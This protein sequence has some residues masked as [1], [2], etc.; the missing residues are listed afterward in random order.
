MAVSLPPIPGLRN[1]LIIVGIIAAVLGGGYLL[2]Q[3]GSNATPQYAPVSLKIWGTDPGSAF[4]QILQRYKA[5]SPNVTATYEQI[6][7]GNYASSLIHAF[8][9]GQ[10]PDVFMIGD[11]DLGAWK[12]LLS[13]ANI[14]QFNI[15]Q[16]DSSYPE[17]VMSDFV[18]DGEVYAL[19]LY[20][21]TLSLVYNKSWFDQAGIAV[22]PATW[23]DFSD[24]V[25][26]LR[27][28]NAQGQLVKTGAAIG[29]S[30]ATI[31]HA[32][33]ILQLL[34][35][36]NGARILDNEGRANFAGGNSPAEKAFEYYLSFADPASENYTWNEDQ[37]DSF[38]QFLTGKTA[39]IFAY[40]EETKKLQERS[41]FL[42]FDIAPVPQINAD[43]PVN[44]PSYQGLGAWVNGASPAWAWNFISFAAINSAAQGDYLNATG[45]LPALRNLIGN[46]ADDPVAGPMVKPALTA[47]SWPM[48]AHENVV[49]IFSDAVSRVL[50]GTMSAAESLTQAEGKLN[51]LLG[52]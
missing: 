5:V 35:L 36:Q 30:E 50:K 15:A 48:P 16:V 2:F 24:D 9:T 13:P 52:K 10:G 37:G 45:R 28:L 19:P 51:Q 33:D 26:K 44:F 23:K 3:S 17:A 49:T 8:A 21:D 40:R 14:R 41:P 22:P 42:N 43:S 47:R 29:G 18:S 1:K 27:T 34:M 38:E 6:P 25:Q 20:M 4:E 12:S 7:P 11:H 31:T 32:A 46:V 39:M